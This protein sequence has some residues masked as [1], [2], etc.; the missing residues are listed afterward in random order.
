MRGFEVSEIKPV[1]PA[2]AGISSERLFR[3]A[4]AAEREVHEWRQS[5]HGGALAK[6]RERD[7]RALWIMFANARVGE[8]ASRR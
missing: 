2:K 1:L 8:L 7:A 4:I 5:E 6:V 3:H